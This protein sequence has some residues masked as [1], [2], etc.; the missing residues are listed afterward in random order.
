MYGWKVDLVRQCAAHHAPRVRFGLVEYGAVEALLNLLSDSASVA[1][2]VP[3]GA[4]AR[5]RIF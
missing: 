1:Q 3:G 2:Q 5:V 4:G